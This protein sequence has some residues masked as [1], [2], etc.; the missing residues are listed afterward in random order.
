MGLRHASVGVRRTARWL[1]SWI[2]VAGMAL[3]VAYLLGTASAA[4]NGAFELLPWG[5]GEAGFLTKV[6]GAPLGQAI[7]GILLIVFGSVVT[8]IS[9]LIVRRR[10]GIPMMSL[11]PGRD[12]RKPIRALQAERAYPQRRIG[13]RMMVFGALSAATAAVMIP[14]FFSIRNT[15]E[16]DGGSLRSGAWVGLGTALFALALAVV[17]LVVGIVFWSRAP[18]R[19]EIEPEVT[20]PAPPMP[21][22]RSRPPAPPMPGSGPTLPAPPGAPA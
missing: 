5:K 14:V 1:G 12:I 19:P 6:W 20:A 3:F 15:I 18:V 17:M 13:R 9:P 8:K 2:A 22:E 10:E 11:R 16:A 7:F 4:S 21:G